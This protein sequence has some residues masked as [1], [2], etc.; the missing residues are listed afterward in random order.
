MSAPTTKINWRESPALIKWLSEHP[1][2]SLIKIAYNGDGIPI[3]CEMELYRS[4]PNEWLEI[5]PRTRAALEKEAD[6]END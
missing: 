5:S 3:V 4:G 6:D 2:W 1:D